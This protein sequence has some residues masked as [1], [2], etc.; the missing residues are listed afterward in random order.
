MHFE[1]DGDIW[2]PFETL[3][4]LELVKKNKKALP[5]LQLLRQ[6]VCSAHVRSDALPLRHEAQTFKGKTTKYILKVC[7][8]TSIVMLLKL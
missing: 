3:K 5:R 4:E 7:T 6:G 1:S 2:R 8:K